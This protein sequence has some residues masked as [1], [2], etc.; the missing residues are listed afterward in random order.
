M[1]LVGSSPAI[2]RVREGIRRAAPLRAAV[3]LSGE[4]G[5]GKKEVARAIHREGASAALPLAIVDGGERVGSD[6]EVLMFGGVPQ[7]SPGLLGSP[8]VGAV[9]LARIDETPIP[10]QRRLLRAI[11]ENVFAPSDPLRPFPVRARLL[12]GAGA[13]PRESVR[14]GKLDRLLGERLALFEISVPPLRDR[15]GDLPDLVGN[16][17][18]RL[19]RKLGRPTPAVDLE[20]R[21]AL[22]NYD[23]PGNVRELR[24]VLE[25]A[26][27]LLEGPVLRESDLPPFRAHREPGVTENLRAARRDFERRHI[28][29]VLLRCGGDK[30]AAARALGVDLT[31]LYRKLSP[32]TP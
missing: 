5:S 23:W 29:R 1:G 26:I 3:F 9:Y 22:Q 2:L 20:A 12:V 8:E 11:E 27:V 19:S 28:Q 31:T 6:L 17:V 24:N 14:Q 7:G 18:A 16:L 15:M 10:F 30:E 21:A 25:Q 13:D 4:P 32:P